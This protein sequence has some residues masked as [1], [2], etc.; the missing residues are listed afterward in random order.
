MRTDYREAVGRAR[1]RLSQW[2]PVPQNP[3]SPEPQETCRFDY[4]AFDIESA[5]MTND[6]TMPDAAEDG[7]RAQRRSR[8]WME[9]ICGLGIGI[10]LGGIGVAVIFLDR[11]RLIPSWVVGWISSDRE[12]QRRQFRLGIY[13][14]IALWAVVQLVRRGLFGGNARTAYRQTLLKLSIVRIKPEDDTHSRIC[15]IKSPR[16]AAFLVVFFTIEVFL[17]WRELGK[18]FVEH[19]LYDLFFR[20]VLWSIVLFPVLLKISRCIPERFIIGIVMIRIVTGWVFEYEPSAVQTVTSLV[21]QCNVALDMIAL[22]TCLGLLISSLSNPE[23][24]TYS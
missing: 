12:T 24:A 8:W 4:L 22:L 18:A 11:M 14:L 10:L 9:I 20:I 19:N 17:S 3:K 5:Q 6:P 13:G 16:I 1:R 15:A 7:F 23:S 2:V 21:R